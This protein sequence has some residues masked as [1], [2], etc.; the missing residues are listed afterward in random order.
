MHNDKA[1]KAGIRDSSDYKDIIQIL[2]NEL[3]FYSL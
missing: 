3:S 1:V 2:L